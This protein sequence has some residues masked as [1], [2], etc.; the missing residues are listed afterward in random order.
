MS[1]DPTVIDVS[2]SIRDLAVL[3]EALDTYEYWELGVTLPRNNG[4][5]WIP[6]DLLA[7]EDY[8]WR[9]LEPTTTQQEAIDAVME[10]RALGTRLLRSLRFGG[11]D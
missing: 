1:E 4:A 5:V 2:L 9:G 10:S 3:C 11:A 7:D 6:G 8:Y